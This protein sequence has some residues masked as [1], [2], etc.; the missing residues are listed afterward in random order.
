M[1]EKRA[2]YRID[3]NMLRKTLLG[4]SV[5]VD[6]DRCSAIESEASAL[7][8][9]KSISL[10]DTKVLIK[11]AVLPLLLIA[12]GIAI[13]VNMDSIQEAFTPAPQVQ[14]ITAT[15]ISVKHAVVKA[16]RIVAAKIVPPPVQNEVVIKKDLVVVTNKVPDSA[17]KQNNK[18][19]LPVVAGPPTDTATSSKIEDLSKVSKPD[20]A[21]KKANDPPVK[22]KKKRRHRSNNIDD[23]KESTLQPNSA[24]DDVVVPQ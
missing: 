11:Y 5:E 8:M 2:T 7:R 9:Q 15:K 10:P 4:Y 1:P 14:N 13:Y 18:Q 16:P 3:E 24:D 17:G 12:G 23:L 19:A 6:A 22:K 20:T 21:S